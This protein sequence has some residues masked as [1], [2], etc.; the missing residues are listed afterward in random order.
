M[1]KVTKTHPPKE[2]QDWLRNNED[3]DRSYK[4]LQGKDAHTKLKRKLLHEQGYL[5]A[6][7]GRRI[8]DESSHVEHIKPQNMCEG[9][10]DIDYKNL[11]ACFPRDGGDTSHGYGAPVKGGDWDQEKFVSPCSEGCERRFAFSWK[12][13]IA[14]SADD[15]EAVDYTIELLE[16]NHS[17][18]E[19]MRSGAIKGFFGFSSQSRALSKADAEKLLPIIDAPDGEGRL[20]PFCFVLKLLLTKYL[21]V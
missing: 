8:Q 14:A 6:Y 19:S 18:L 17:S 7:T 10:E 4:A 15:D 11:L 3:L 16:L 20:R 9:T 12:G 21:K 13:K 5:C 2:F 1:N